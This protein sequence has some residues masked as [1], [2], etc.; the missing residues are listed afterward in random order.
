MLAPST[1]QALRNIRAGY[2]PLVRYVR[3]GN[4]ESKGLVE[5]VNGQWR[6]TDEGTN[7]LIQHNAL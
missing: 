2:G 1:I 7:V 5:K 4:L 3:M 6:I